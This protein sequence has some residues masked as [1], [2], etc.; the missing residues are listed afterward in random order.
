V[1]GAAPTSTRSTASLARNPSAIA[2]AISRVFP[3]ID[4]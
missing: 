3:N 2:L 4:S 1:A